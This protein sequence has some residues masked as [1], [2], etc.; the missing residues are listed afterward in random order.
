MATKKKGLLTSSG[1]WAK[2]LRKFNK[3]KFW[4]KERQKEKKMVR[5]ERVTFVSNKFDETEWTN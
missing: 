4:K 3:G 2:H 5:Q 1:E